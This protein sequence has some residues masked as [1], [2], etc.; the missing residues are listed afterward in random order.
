M[1][2]YDQGGV[3]EGEKTE[4]SNTRIDPQALQLAK[5]RY[6]GVKPAWHPPWKLFR[7]ISGHTGLP[8]FLFFSLFFSLFLFVS[9]WFFFL[10]AS[11]SILD[12]LFF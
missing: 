3:G 1:A 6:T 10:L 11:F 9:L 7:V 8:F 12:P 4:T 2:L 5:K